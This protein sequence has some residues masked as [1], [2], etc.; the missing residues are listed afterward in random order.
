MAGRPQQRFVP[1]ALSA[2]AALVLAPVGAAHAESW[3]AQ[4]LTVHEWGVHV[5]GGD[6]ARSSLLAGLPPW[7]HS[8]TSGGVASGPSV[9]DLPVDSGIRALPVI[10][11]YSPRNWQATVPVGVE[12]GFTGGPA[13][14]WFPQVDLL[15]TAADANSADS[16][17]A[18]AKLL[19]ARLQ[20]QGRMDAP[21]ALPLDPTRQ[22]V[23]NHLDLA[24]TP[25]HP[26]AASTSA[27]VDEARKLDALWVN[28]GAESERFLFY[29]AD[30]REREPLRL[31]RGTAWSADHRQYVLRNDG[32]QPVH[33]VFVVQ[34]DGGATF[35]VYVATL[36][37]GKST[38]FVLEDH[39]VEPA[40]LRAATVD[41]LRQLLVEPDP[42]PAGDRTRELQDCV[43][44]RDPAL[45]FETAH[46]YRLFAPEVDLILHT[47]GARFFERPGT[48]IV[49]R[50]DTATLEA[51]MPLSIYTD[52]YNFVVLR[53]AGLA[54]WE[55]AAL[56]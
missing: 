7:F 46:G 55:A 5:F 40:G 31:A 43:M 30:T 35:V 34:R 41:R 8:S 42:K 23:W 1:L 54:L 45:P 17:L 27:W 11:F 24:P 44:M 56:P 52:M 14:S 37:A 39:R 38:D 22:L 18:R 33:D 9:R 15:R 29:E 10:H 48:T 53:R 47:W 25:A 4:A 16:Q 26:P 28:G 2:L 50:E 3:C 51:A 6:G 20:R 49:Y 12:V 32:P 21:P 13:S 19:L 36:E